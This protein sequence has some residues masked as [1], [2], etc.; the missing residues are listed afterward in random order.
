MGKCFTFN[1]YDAINGVRTISRTGSLL[2]LTLYLRIDQN[3]YVYNNF[4]AAGVK[5]LV[6]DPHEE[7][8]MV[9]LG[10]LASP[11]YSVNAAIKMTKYKYLPSPYL[12]FGDG[13]CLDTKSSTFKNHLKYYEHYSESACLRECK[14]NIIVGNE[15]ICSLS[16]FYLCY[17]HEAYI[18]DSDT[19]SLQKCDCPKPCQFTQYTALSSSAVFPARVYD[20]PLYLMGMTNLRDDYIELNI[21]Y[22]SLTY[23][24]VEQIPQFTIESIIGILGG[25]MGIFLGASLLTL[26]ELVE[27]GILSLYVLL[28]RFCIKVRGTRIKTT[29]GFPDARDAKVVRW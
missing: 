25:Q 24:Y 9:N 28:K 13:Y 26:S 4:M 1:N 23:Q 20:P 10:Y 27:F 7:P 15:T 14:R 29:E 17:D 18:F 22:E 12:A 19:S 16:E 5:F 8:D 6:H 21:F 3:E 11:G 2:S